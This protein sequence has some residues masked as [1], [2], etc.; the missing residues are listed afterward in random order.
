MADVIGA[1]DA[2]QIAAIRAAREQHRT[3]ALAADWDR[4]MAIVDDEAVV[5]P[6]N[7]PPL[8]TRAKI[9]A[10]CENFPRITSFTMK[11][12]EIDGRADLAYE[13]GTFDL[14]AGGV[15]LRGSHLTLWRKQA[16]GSWKIFRD[17]WHSDEPA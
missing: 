9:R 13:R 14:T 15:Q 17:I 1:L 3:R 10:F 12:A 5:L 6:P 11:T 4:F 7:S 2:A 8:E 16:D